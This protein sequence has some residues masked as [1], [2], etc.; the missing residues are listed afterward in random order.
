TVV[1]FPGSRILPGDTDGDGT[2]T[3]ISFDYT[4]FSD[5]NILTA[6]DAFG[7]ASSVADLKEATRYLVA[8]SQNIAAADSQGSVFYTGYQAVPCRGYLP[9][10]ADGSWVEGADPSLLL[11]GTSYGGFEIP[12][13]DDGKPVEGDP[14]PSRCLVPFDEYPNAVNPAKGYVVN[15]NNDPGGF[16]LDND[17]LN[18]PWYIGGPWVEGFRANRISELIEQGIAD[19]SANPDWMARIQ[20]DHKSAL[21]AWFS[22]HL[23]EAIDAG[24]AASAK[25]AS[26]ATTEDTAQARLAALYDQDPTAMDEVES[27]IQAWADR[28]YQAES[29]VATF[30]STATDDQVADS[31]ATTVFNAWLG[32]WYTTVFGDE[33]LPDVW[34]PGGN[35]GRVRAL[36]MFLEGRGADNPG[37]L[38]S[39]NDATGESIFFDVLGTDQIE[40]SDEDALSALLD[41][42]A[43]LESAPTA[44]LRGSGFGTTDMEQWRWGMRH[45]TRFE[46]ILNDF[47]G[48]DSYSF[49]T[50]QFNINTDVL[51]LEGDDS[52]ADLEWFPRPG[53]NLGVDAANPGW[54]TDFTHS[55]G[56]VFRMVIELGPDGLVSGRNILPGGQSAM[57]DSAYFADQA[58]L[59]LANNT[60]PMRLDASDVA[61]HTV[62]REHFSGSGGGCN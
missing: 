19:G 26:A 28:D 27:R 62:T 20:G 22:W 1:V 46:S 2:I 41:A 60:V 17:L 14:D 25:K 59:W 9:R 8:Y 57:T 54:G 12:I 42:L 48:G 61:A 29:G 32:Y 7:H 58:A 6:V 21:G 11:D 15:S 40:T 51:P 43:F 53:D 30:Y 24:R 36:T 18:E 47:L 44:D 34:N 16:T 10:N 13:G 49:I 50:D 56:P 45:Q 37:D 52:T 4:A 31:I 5:G 55:S 33:S 3:A 35:T 39:W 23:V 38:A